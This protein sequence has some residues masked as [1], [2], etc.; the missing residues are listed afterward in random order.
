MAN[1]INDDFYRRYGDEN[2]QV[3]LDEDGIEELL[4]DNLL[5][6][7]NIHLERGQNFNLLSD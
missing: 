5:T 1:L 4:E 2:G 6:T 3:V 7:L